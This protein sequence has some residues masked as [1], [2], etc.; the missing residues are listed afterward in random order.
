[1]Q[2][3]LGLKVVVTIR[4]VAEE[5]GVSIQT[6]SRVINNRYDVALK[7]RQRVQHAIDRLGYQPNAIARGLATRRSK[8]LGVV[9]YDFGDYF[10][11]Q[12]VIGAEQVAYKSG[13]VIM[14]GN[15]QSEQQDEPKYL[16]LLTKHHVDGILFARQIDSHTDLA[17]LDI[18]NQSGV[19]IV[20]P[21]YHDSSQNIFAV[22]ID[23]NSGARQAVDCLIQNGHRN[24]AMITGP[25]QSLFA[26]DRS[27]GFR[28]AL[29]AAGLPYRPELVFEG[30][31]T[32]L[33]GYQAAEQLI[34]SKHNFTA[35]FVQSDRMA[36]GA[37]RALHEAKLRV[38][39]DISVMGYDDIPEAAFS[40]PSLTTI[41]QPTIEVGRE[42]MR[43]LIRKIEDPKTLPEQIF[44]HTELV[45]RESVA[46]IG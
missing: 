30:A 35:V 45:W 9:T 39:E 7:T 46:S 17:N 32:Y 27:Q 15:A 21:G 44:L 25:A 41:H 4:Q 18:L 43:M 31:Y 33:S 2:K 14:L 19:P 36:I 5:A 24:I 11:A 6:V 16:H 22:D 37:L 12:I 23:N 42:S 29:A 20:L 3:E 34:N 10:F 1:V 28:S 8:T 26:M 38:P 13:Y 40:S